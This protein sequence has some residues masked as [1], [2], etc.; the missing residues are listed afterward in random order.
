[1][2]K[3]LCVLLVV[4]V[5][6]GLVGTVAFS[7]ESG[8]TLTI[9]LMAEPDGLNMILTPAAASFQIVMYNI[10]EPL[11]RYT[12]DRKIEPLLAT[13]YEVADIG[14]ETYC[15]FHLREGV[16]FHN[17]APF[18]ANDVKYTFDKLLDPKTASPNASLFS[19]VKE[20]GVIDPLTVRF[21]TQGAGAPLIGYLAS[22]KGTGIIPAGSDMD[23]LRTHPIG[24]GPFEF[25]EWTPGDHITLVRNSDYWQAGA[26]YLD[27]VI[28][29]FI[30]DQAA[31]LAALRAGNVDLVDL[32]VGENALQIENDP[33]LKVI[34]GSQNLVQILA[35]N[36]SRPPFDNVL[37]RRAICYA[38]NRAEIIAATDLKPEWGS[39]IG[40]HMTPLSP[41]YVDLVGRY[42]YDPDKARA[43]LAQAGYPNGFSTTIYLPQPYEFHI[44]TG[45]IIADELRE[46]GIN[47]KLEI[48]EWGQWLDRVY[49]QWDYDMTVIAHDVSI[50]PAANFTKGFEQAQEDGS[51]AYY[52]QYTNDYLR[53]LLARGRETNDLGERKVI[54][55]MVQA[56]ISDDAVM[57]W[58]QV[59]HQLEGMNAKVMGY[60]ILPLYVLDLGSIYWEGE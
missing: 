48:L 41:Y 1:M 60:H 51:S 14:A 22:A 30:P 37:V 10:N 44:R 47:C 12:A 39:P 58:I 13:S 4:V 24:T 34:S 36:N 19:F 26:P 32:M 50:E 31:S 17:G 6:I 49:K 5:V 16:R 3:T 7:Q 35:M 25:L 29:R 45:Q 28:C 55:A 57:A 43:L 59:P 38:I 56:L 27:K 2:N 40:S 8:G 52:W 20:V 53:D 21:V 9:A 42:P 15:T 23:A 18:T 33:A 46:V 54:Y 11:L